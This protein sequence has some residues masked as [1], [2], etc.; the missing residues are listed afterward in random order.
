MD[1]LGKKNGLMLV[2]AI[3]AVAMGFMAISLSHQKPEKPKDSFASEIENI[4][5][6]S[7]STNIGAI[8]KDLNET[9]LNN[10]D[11]ELQQIENELNQ[12]L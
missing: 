12:A 9:E 3:L 1:I 6:Q 11:R 5:T 8:E 7:Q 2:A 4:Q 10:I